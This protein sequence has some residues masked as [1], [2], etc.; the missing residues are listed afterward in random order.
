MTLSEH[1]RRPT[2]AP[3]AVPLH[4]IDRAAPRLTVSLLGGF[5]LQID[6]A[7]TELPTT[8]Q[9]LVAVLA[10]R[11]RGSRSRL[12]GTLWP[13][14]SEQRA[15][16]SLRTAIWRVN[17]VEHRLL[18]CTGDMIELRPSV[19]VDSRRF[20]RH[21]VRALGSRDSDET[22]EPPSR[23]GGAPS[24]SD[25]EYAVEVLMTDGDLL[26]D[27]DDDWVVPER[28]RLRQLRLHVLED[29]SSRL[30]RS[31]DYGLALETAL[32]ALRVD[33]LRESAYRSLIRV[34]VAEGNVTDARRVLVRCRQVLVSEVGVEPS[35]ETLA[36]LGRDAMAAT[37]P[38]AVV[39][40]QRGGAAGSVRNG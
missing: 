19:D 20:L 36:L 4:S 3:A 10:V 24:L 9:R 35:Y 13:E 16:A 31:G 38:R 15:L 7:G 6:G 2:R 30:C 17:Q 39:P 32:A 8:A 37:R 28:E 11:G 14:A 1:V 18:R 23:P 22:W 5:H 21:A 33:P 25:P 34:H 27:W 29:L 40:Q 12:A 26:P